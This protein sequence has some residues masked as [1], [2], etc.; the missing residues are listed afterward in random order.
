L[1][2]RSR[3]IR[4]QLTLLGLAVFSFFWPHSFNHRSNN[5]P[6]Y[7]LKLDVVRHVNGAI[8]GLAIGA[9]PNWRS[10]RTR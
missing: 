6:E 3:G 4:F 2:H 7:L 8:D 5:N 1:P 10:D 9:W